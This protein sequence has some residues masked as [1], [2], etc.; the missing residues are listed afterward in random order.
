MS[1]EIMV[2]GGFVFLDSLESDCS[3][4]RVLRP[5]VVVLLAGCS[6]AEPVSDMMLD[7]YGG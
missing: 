7:R 1:L 4:K 2:C 3:D 6:H 5:R